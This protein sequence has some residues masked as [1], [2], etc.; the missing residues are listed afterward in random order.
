MAESDEAGRHFKG[1]YST[2]FRLSRE[3]DVPD[4][5]E[6]TAG[7]PENDCFRGCRKVRDIGILIRGLLTL[8]NVRDR[9]K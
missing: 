9:F 6:M 2:T 1:C 4:G 7:R 5:C 8:Q 3:N